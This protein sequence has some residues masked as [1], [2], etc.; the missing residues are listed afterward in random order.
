MKIVSNTGPLIGLAKIN[1]LDILKN[2]SGDVLIPPAV[3]REL[4]GKVGAESSRIDRA[5]SDFV[6]V[7]EVTPLKPPVKQ[8]LADLDEGERQAIG[9]A[10][11]LSDKILLLLDDRAGRAAARELKIP[12]T[13]LIGILLLA[14]EKGLIKKVG[15]QIDELRRQGYWVSDD[16]VQTAKEL[17]GEK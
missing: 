4:L 15:P 3:H 17:A 14:K 6:H 8:A 13:G 10:S 9:L 7:T 2:L 12:T 16:V 1:L 11:S 5:L